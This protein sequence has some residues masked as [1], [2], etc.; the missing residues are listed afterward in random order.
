MIASDDTGQ[1]ARRF[2]LAAAPLFEQETATPG[3]HAVL[4][5]G[6]SGSFAMSLS[7]EEL[8]R[9]PGPA[10]W[11]WSSD[12]PH[13][14]TVTAGKVAVLRWDRPAD[15]RVFERGSIE[16]NLERFYSFL[17]GDRLRS[18]RGVVE[19]LLSFFRRLR[20]LAHAAGLPDVRATDILLQHWHSC[21]RRRT[22]RHPF[23]AMAWLMTPVRCCA[24]S[25]HVG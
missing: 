17:T 9:G 19:H 3:S 11:I 4:L 24:D 5:D 1:W 10:D 7:D 16:R 21:W 13:H 23:P 18:N 12:V 8:W 2:G 25:I 22:R 15:A 14:V 20:S 6:A